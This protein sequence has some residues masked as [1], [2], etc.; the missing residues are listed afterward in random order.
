MQNRDLDSLM[1][2]TEI[3]VRSD[4]V[5]LWICEVWSRSVLNDPE[6]EVLFSPGDSLLDEMKAWT[7]AQ[8]GKQTIMVAYGE[9]TMWNHFSFPTEEGATMFG[10]RW[11]GA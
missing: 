2:K 10:M 1:F 11:S 7:I 6:T 5:N 8:G 4:E 3:R 9:Q